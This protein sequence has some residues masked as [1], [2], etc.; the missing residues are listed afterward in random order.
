MNVHMEHERARGNNKTANQVEIPK[1]LVFTPRKAFTTE[2][3]NEISKVRQEEETRPQMDQA[4]AKTGKKL[5]FTSPPTKRAQ[6]SVEKRWMK[7]DTAFQYTTQG[8]QDAQHRLISRLARFPPSKRYQEFMRMGKGKWCPTTACLNWVALR[9]GLQAIGSFESEFQIPFRKHLRHLNA[10]AMKYKR[11]SPNPLTAK[12]L[13]KILSMYREYPTE[14]TVL[15]LSFIL[16]QRVPDVVKLRK[17]WV[18][19]KRYAVAVTFVEGKVIPQIG[20][21]TLFLPRNSIGACILLHQVEKLKEATGYIFK[22]PDLS[23]NMKKIMKTVDPHLTDI[24]GVR[25]GGLMHMATTGT[26][27]QVIL[28]FSKHS[29]E[30]MLKTYLEEGSLLVCEAKAQTAR[31]A[32]TERHIA[33]LA[34][35]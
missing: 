29:S 23:R 24:R 8:Y 12:H 5:A 10:E 25:R 33:S 27:T 35:T 18:R 21:Y 14:V 34:A 6:S 9:T 11:K 31:V 30:R 13:R 28:S 4:N 17:E 16:G 26:A 7:R 32:E 19:V 1:K 15:A 20:P 22:K 3:W 2:K